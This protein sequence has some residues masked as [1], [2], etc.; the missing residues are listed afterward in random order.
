VET[1]DDLVATPEQVGEVLTGGGVSADRLAER[2]EAAQAPTVPSS[3]PEP[4]PSPETV[5]QA[6]AP[7]DSAVPQAPAPQESAVPQAPAPQES[8]APEVQPADPEFGIE[9]GPGPQ[10]EPGEQPAGQPVEEPAGAS[11][12]DRISD[13]RLTEQAENDPNYQLPRTAFVSPS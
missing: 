1:E 5:P 12:P 11:V 2:A 9:A 3:T 4:V 13:A 6:P 8:A 7:Q 10:P